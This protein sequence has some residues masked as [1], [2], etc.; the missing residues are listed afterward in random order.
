[1]SRDDICVGVLPDRLRLA[2]AEAGLSAAEVARRCGVSA[3]SMQSWL[4]GD[5]QPSARNAALVAYVTQKPI[6]YLF[7]EDQDGITPQIREDA[8]LG[9]K[10]RE[11]LGVS[12]G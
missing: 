3:Q 6:G 8:E 7:G 4:N 1:M 11:L 10:V 9:R 2:I 12:A 5:K